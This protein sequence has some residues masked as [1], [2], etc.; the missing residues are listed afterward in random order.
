MVGLAW[1]AGA[2]AMVRADQV[3]SKPQPPPMTVVRVPQWET[4]QK[5]FQLVMAHDI[6]AWDP[7]AAAVAGFRPME[8]LYAGRTLYVDDLT[9]VS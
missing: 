6:G 3:G 9:R 8:K 2:G 5:W 1:M 7:S 4:T